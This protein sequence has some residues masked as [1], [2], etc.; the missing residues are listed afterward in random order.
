MLEQLEAG[1]D[2]A[3]YL[4]R[5]LDES[6]ASHEIVVLS[7]PRAHQRWWKRTEKRLRLL[8]SVVSRIIRPV[9]SFDLDGDPA[10]VVFDD[11][12]GVTLTTLLQGGALQL[13]SCYSVAV[14]LAEGLAEAHRLGLVHGSLS[15]GAVTCDDSGTPAI[16]LSGIDTGARA[17]LEASPLDS[18]C[19]APE[20]TETGVDRASDVYGLGAI[21]HCCLTGEPPVGGP[22]PDIS[23]IDETTRELLAKMLDSRPEARPSTREVVKG[24]RSVVFDGAAAPRTI[25]DASPVSLGETLPRDYEALS[26]RPQ[27]GRDEAL[28]G[29]HHLTIEPGTRLGRYRIVEPLGAGAMG[30]VYRAEDIGDGACVALKVLAPHSVASEEV[31]E[32]FRK[33]ARILSR[34][35]SPYVANLI[36]TNE[37]Q[38]VRYIASELVEGEDLE[39][40]LEEKRQLPER[41]ALSIMTDVARALCDVHE[42]GIVHRDIK[43]A[44]IILARGTPDGAPRIK[45]VDFGIARETVAGEGEE[46]RDG[47]VAGTPWYMAPEQCLGTKLGPA[48]DM[49]AAGATIFHLIAGRPPF[50]DDNLRTLLTKQV[51]DTPPRLKEL[52]P[53]VGDETDTLVHQTLAKDPEDRPEAVSEILAAIEEILGISTSTISDHPKLPAHQPESLQE[54][55]FEWTLKASP[56]EIWPLISDTDR[57]NAAVGLKPVSYQP[58]ADSRAMRGYQAASRVAGIKLAW[59]EHAFEWVERRQHSV[60]REFDGGLLNWYANKVVLDSAPEGGTHVVHTV[61]L[62]PRNIVARLIS[63][64]EIGRK[65]KAQLELLYRRFDEHA[66]EIRLKSVP[67]GSFPVSKRPMSGK[68]NARLEKG[69]AELLEVGVDQAAAQKLGNYLR[70]MSKQ[71]L[72]R[73]RPIAL[74]RKLDIGEQEMVEACL[75]ST[76]VGLLELLWDLVCPVCR[77]PTQVGES[78]GVIDH[79]ARCEACDLDFA[80]D[81]D[82]AVELIFRAHPLIRET[83]VRTFCIGGPGYS[84]H[85]V[86]QLRL[87]PKERFLLELDLADGTY[88]LASRQLGSHFDFRVER[89]GMV[90][91]LDITLSAAGLTEELPTTLTPVR[92]VLVLHNPHDEAILVRVERRA[93]RRDALSASRAGAMALFRYLFP[94]ELLAPELQLATE[95]TTFLVTDGDEARISEQ[96]LF[97]EELGGAVV[98]ELA[99]GVFASFGAAS[100]AVRA[101]GGMLRQHEGSS[102]GRVGLR[103]AVH[104][105]RAMVETVEGRL[106]YSGEASDGVQRLLELAKPGRLVLARALSELPEIMAVCHEQGLGSEVVSLPEGADEGW[107]SSWRVL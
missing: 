26:V 37:D 62:S 43:P 81:F 54:Y 47:S 3:R 25:V 78:L 106:D 36:E 84:P 97:V 72:S 13:D 55:R 42:R 99:A 101:A 4:A 11:A 98:R 8:R 6:A 91:R 40:Y 103:V 45:L 102:N 61:L 89:P 71:D 66:S 20:R 82:G 90:S 5:S 74:A 15:P 16:D 18:A 104:R 44:N 24:L 68:A 58:V 19:L 94:D 105:G 12:R 57:V 56:S 85:V 46:S 35:R 96:A 39:V 65:F 32:Q 52:E 80:V 92:Q 17:R 33:E 29:E 31:L 67:W 59:H 53:S 14:L 21:M 75:Q 76:Q 69:L 34:V 93:G 48:V 83:E 79:R 38:G 22:L 7:R 87:E 27:D 88:R 30:A 107:V 86:A 77:I 1:A 10:T 28:E 9:L 100:E 73:I 64:V 41:E 23:D 60:L 51:W 2:G 49:Y 63:R 70:Y 50:D 95:N